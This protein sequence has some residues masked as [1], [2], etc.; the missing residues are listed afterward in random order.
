MNDDPEYLYGPSLFLAAAVIC[1]AVN[2]LLSPK[3]DRALAASSF[4]NNGRCDEWLGRAGLNKGQLRQMVA[5]GR[6]RPLPKQHHRR[7]GPG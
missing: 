5:E 1:Q 2:D 7:G 3:P 4:L 6:R